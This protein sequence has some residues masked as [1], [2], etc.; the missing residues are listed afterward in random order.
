MADKVIDSL[1]SW[2]IDKFD[3]V[4]KILSHG[5]FRIGPV[6]SLWSITTLSNASGSYRHSGLIYGPM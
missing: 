3:R 4:I 6:S 1:D 2:R 5:C